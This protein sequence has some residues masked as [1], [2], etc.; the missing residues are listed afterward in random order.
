MERQRVT[1]QHLCVLWRAAP[2]TTKPTIGRMMRVRYN[3]P[4]ID[5][6]IRMLMSGERTADKWKWDGLI[7]D[8]WVDRP[9]D[10]ETR[11]VAE[12]VEYHEFTFPEHRDARPAH[13]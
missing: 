3:N 4:E 8:C 12:M 13:Q 11:I 10:I 9:T 6:T 5:R 2:E 1:G 7:E